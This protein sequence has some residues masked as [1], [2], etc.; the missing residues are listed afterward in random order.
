M[1][2][3]GRKLKS[4]PVPVAW[5]SK[6]LVCGCLLAGTVGSNPAGGMNICFL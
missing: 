4:W 2:L 3:L 5:L 6:A 1:N